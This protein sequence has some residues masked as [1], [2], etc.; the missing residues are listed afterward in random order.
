MP[1]ASPAIHLAARLVRPMTLGARVVA[2]DAEER[3]LLVKHSYL[4]GWYLPGGGVEPGETLEDAARRETREETGVAVTGP[5]T[6]HG[7]FFNRQ[8]S[9]RDHVAVFVA[10]AFERPATLPGPD[11]EIA[12]RRFFPL[13]GLPADLAGATRARLDEIAGRA[14]RSADW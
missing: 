7:M 1:F 2:I 5:M 13:D 6:L 4:K 11:L 3:V 10:R 8:A 14:P 12:E 9:R